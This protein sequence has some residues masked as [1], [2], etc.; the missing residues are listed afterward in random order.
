M[1]VKIRKRIGICRVDKDGNIIELQREY[2]GQ[3]WV[4]K[5]W[6]AFQNRPDA[7]CYVPELDDAVYT[8][9]DFMALCNG[10]EE[11]AEE[12]FYEVDWQSPSTLMNDWEI[13]GEI[14]TCGNCGKLLM[15]YS[16]KKCPHC[17]ADVPEG[18][19]Y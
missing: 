9:N 12:L 14:A 7:P 3:G 6:E 4:F 15:S 10:Q 16:V 19:L 13:A 8:K 11:I 17:G 2:F 1:A 18:Q 5:D